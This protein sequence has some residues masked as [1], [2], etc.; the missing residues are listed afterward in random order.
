MGI[1]IFGTSI[2]SG[3]LLMNERERSLVKE[4]LQVSLRI[5]GG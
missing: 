2:V 1:G 3:I 4:L 5:R